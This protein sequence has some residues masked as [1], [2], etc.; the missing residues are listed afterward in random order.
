MRDTPGYHDADVANFPY[1]N[2]EI[3]EYRPHFASSIF[4]LRPSMACDKLH[5]SKAAECNLVAFES[6]SSDITKSLFESRIRRLGADVADGLI[7]IMARSSSWSLTGI[8][9]EAAL[10]E[11]PSS[12]S[13][14]S[15]TFLRRTCFSTYLS[16]F[17]ADQEHRLL[18]LASA[19]VFRS[20]EML[21]QTR[22]SKTLYLVISNNNSTKIRNEK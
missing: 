9:L 6:S 11:Y 13:W 14:G 3:H 19:A 17:F 7:S 8:S 22:K 2:D 5:K 16:A 12:D 18:Y 20:C 4:H 10:R 15:L 1:K 21:V